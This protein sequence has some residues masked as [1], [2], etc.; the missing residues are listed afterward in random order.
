MKKEIEKASL[1]SIDE[2]MPFVVEWD[3]SK[4]AVSA[5]L[6]QNGRPVAFM[7]RSLQGNEL[8]YPAVEKEA[9]A[10]IEAVHKW[11]HFLSRKHFIL[12]TDQRSASFMLD[13]HKRTI[14]KNN[15]ILYWRLE[16]ASYSYYFVELEKKILL[17]NHLLKIFVELW[18]HLILQKYM[19]LFA[20]LALQGYYTL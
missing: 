1:Q 10:I 17:Q 2:S 8:H 20:I 19:L 18:R 6:N 15:K 7:S 5:T 13:K 11:N 4:V 12:V 14:I 3:A 9:S 16:L